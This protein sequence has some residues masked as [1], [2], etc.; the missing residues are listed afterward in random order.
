MTAFASRNDR[1]KHEAGQ[2]VLR[3]AAARW[4]TAFLLRAQPRRFIRGCHQ[5]PIWK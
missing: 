1:L 4:R 5:Q 3:R 2:V